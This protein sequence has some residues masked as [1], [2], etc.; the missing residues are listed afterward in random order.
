M[1]KII[2]TFLV[3]LFGFFAFSSAQEYIFFYGNGCPH[4]ASVE[5]FFQENNVVEKYDVDVREMYFN[6]DNL[7]TFYYYIDKLGIDNSRAGVPF[8]VIDNDSNCNYLM[9]DVKIIDFFESL[10]ETESEQIEDN[11]YNN[12][13]NN[14]PNNS[15]NN[16]TQEVHSS[17]PENLILSTEHNDIDENIDNVQKD[18][19]SLDEIE[20]CEEINDEEVSG[21]LETESDLEN[22]AGNH[23]KFLGI[24]MP[25]AL[26]DSINPCAF[27]VMLILLSTILVETKN[28]KRAILAGLLFAL[29]IFISYFAMGLGLFSAL[30]TAGNTMLIK[31]IVGILGIIV[32]LAN[33]KDFFR[34]GKGF[35]MEVPLSRRPRL[36]KTIK[37]IVSP[38]G[39]F[40]TGFVISLF[41]LPC[42]SG[43]YIT[44]LG[45]LASESKNINL[46]GYIYLAIYN[47]IFIIPMLIITLL[48][49][50][51]FKSAEELAAI[52]KKNSKIIHLIVG[53]LM[54]GL[55]LYV[56]LTM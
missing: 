12:S 25:A 23:A 53:L 55:G 56:L 21:K 46:R 37:S 24:M 22:L 1:K 33:L 45:Y 19:E 36:Q 28:K 17:I 52:K 50:L 39:A 27:A 10:I 43:P 54:L 8:L 11:L 31:R 2:L 7:D 34:Y 15:H 51:G 49:G 9:G 29:S 30:A 41:L 32:G 5:N 40:F 3:L 13:T 14:S 6:R 44:I 35:I 16:D 42:T 38:I 4:C 48:V 26:A 20:Q 18:N 47:I